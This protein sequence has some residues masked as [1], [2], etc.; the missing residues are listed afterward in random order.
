MNTGTLRRFPWHRI[1]VFLVVVALLVAA[2]RLGAFDAFRNP[3]QVRALIDSW[4]PWAYVLY[5]VTFISLMPFGV[6]AFVWV[7]PAGV[8]WPFWLAFPL[9]LIAVAGA[10]TVGFLFARY[11]ARDWVAAHMPPRIRRIDERFC[12]RGLRSV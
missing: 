2:W 11:I 5:L 1:A 6:P 7:L 8:L 3:E 10:S 9:S 4:G 12:A